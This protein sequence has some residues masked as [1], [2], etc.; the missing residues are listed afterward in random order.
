MKNLNSILIAFLAVLL[1]FGC[2][3][4]QK[5]EGAKTAQEPQATRFV[6]IGTGG[7]TGVYY[8]TGGAISKLVNAKKDQYKIRMTVESTG[9]S[10]FNVNAIMSGDIEFGVVQSDRQYQALKGMKNWEGKPQEKLRAVFSIHPESVTIVAAVDSGIS[11]VE[12]LKGKVVNIGN[13]GSGQR[14]NATDLFMAAGIDPDKDMQTE[15]LKAAE[16]AGMLQDGRLDAFFYTVGHP[17]GSVKEAV[18]GTRQVQ[19]VSVP[20]DIVQK[21]V[22]KLPFYAASKIPIKY[23]PGVGNKED[24]KT[25][26]V[27]ATL[28]T[29]A[30]VPEDIVYNV[31]KE[32][33][34]NLDTFKTLHPAFADLTKEEMLKGL[35]APLHPGAEKY[36]KEAGLL[37]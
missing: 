24:V 19:F 16:S 1:C 3:S 13:P 8:P 7:V 14:G 23:Y 11:T 15:G 4:E 36:F 6:T 12:D 35:S 29:H 27:K 5:K 32:V 37:K 28:C 10:V 26:G 20:D 22:D 9:G 30:D 2:Q 31:T 33:F 34:E 18:A 21:L 25:F 17:N